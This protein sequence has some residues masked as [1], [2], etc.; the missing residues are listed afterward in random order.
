MIHIKKHVELVSRNI[1]LKLRLSYSVIKIFYVCFNSCL[2][3]VMLDK[4]FEVAVQMLKQL[5]EKFSPQDMLNVIQRSM[6]LLTEAY[7]H[8]MASEYYTL[9][10]IYI[11]YI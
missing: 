5:Q 6:E 2:N 11:L 8:A 4:Q 1:Y 3:A 7:E 10:Y 9:L